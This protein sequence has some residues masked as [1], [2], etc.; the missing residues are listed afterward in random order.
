MKKIFSLL[1]AAALLAGLAGCGGKNEANDD[2]NLGVWTAKTGEMLGITIDV[3]DM[4]DGGFTIELKSGG[5]CALT[6]SGKKANGN[7]TLDNGAFSVKGG[8]IDCKGRL[9]NGKLTLEDVMD[10]GIT[11]H[12]E[13]EGGWQAASTAEPA[14]TAGSGTAKADYFKLDSM[15]GS[16]FGDMTVEEYYEMMESFGASRD[17]I[18]SYVLMYPDG[19]VQFVMFGMLAEGTYK[20]GVLDLE[21]DG[22][23]ATLEY[24]LSGDKLTVTM[25]D[26]GG[27]MVFKRSSETPP[28]LPGGSSGTGSSG[29]GSSG[30]GSSGAGSSGLSDALAWWDGE[31]YGYWTVTSA[32]GDY[33]SWEDGVWD[34]YAV[35]KVNPDGTAVMYVW[36]DD[37]DM[38]VAE[39]FIEEMGGVGFMGSATSEGGE[40][41]EVSLRHAD[42]VIMPAEKGYKDYWGNEAYGDYMEFNGYS[43][44]GRDSLSYEIVL[45]PWGML[46]NDIPK[47]ERP[48]DYE[49][50]YA[51]DDYYKYSSL[52]DALA[53]T[54]VG[55]EPANIHSALAGGS[56]SGGRP[57]GGSGSG[58]ND[59]Q[60]GSLSGRYYRDNGNYFEFF[61]DGTCLLYF[62]FMDFSLETRYTVSGNTITFADDGEIDNS[63]AAT[64]S[65]DTITWMDDVYKK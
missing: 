45:R 10:M 28:S 3:T 37:I 4:F 42:W 24:K 51:G 53:D 41:F 40:A 64:L 27:E 62:K 16:D 35:I 60:G 34:C 61:P 55:G 21:A 2:P 26:D 49:S 44:D 39:I 31:W 63:E 5:K 22:D 13:K 23:S 36:D 43:E 18:L 6:V 9:E 33:E 59:S 50:W 56:S 25:D 29:A 38:A 58:G 65:G 17:E 47:N 19:K 8:G 7:W 57:S 46:W 15:S 30:T 52:L 14:G 48:P 11:L 1:L 32:Y 12:F 20:N 54:T